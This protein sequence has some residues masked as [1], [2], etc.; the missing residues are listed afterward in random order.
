[1][2]LK[3][4]SI[5]NAVPSS[6]SDSRNPKYKYYLES[7]IFW[8]LWIFSICAGATSQLRG[9]ITYRIYTHLHTPQTYFLPQRLSGSQAGAGRHKPAVSQLPLVQ[10]M[11]TDP[12]HEQVRIIT[13]LLM[14]KQTQREREK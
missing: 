9:N 1:M 8:S 6:I 4:D 10:I 3:T 7:Q 13:Q 12:I 5:L 14:E 11:G 2:D